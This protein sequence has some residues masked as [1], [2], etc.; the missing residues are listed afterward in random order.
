MVLLSHVAL[1]PADDGRMMLTVCTCRW[2][3]CTPS[4]VPAA[5]VHQTSDLSAL[6]RACRL[7][8]GGWCASFLRHMTLSASMVI[9]LFELNMIA[10]NIGRRSNHRS[11]SCSQAVLFVCDSHTCNETRLALEKLQPGG[12]KLL[13][14]IVL[15]LL[16]NRRCHLLC[17]TLA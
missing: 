14:V 10:L 8:L 17:A 2:N 13:I 15:D 12:R 1:L 3:I 16:Q 7:L 11:A 9:K 5:G 4:A 6:G